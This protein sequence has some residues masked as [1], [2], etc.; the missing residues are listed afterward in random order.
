VVQ[1]VGFAQTIQVWVSFLPRWVVFTSS[2]DLNARLAGWAPA[3]ELASLSPELGVSKPMIRRIVA[4]FPTPF[5]PARVAYI[6]Q[7]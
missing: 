2:R 5:G 6:L 4:V 7:H 1:S 3:D